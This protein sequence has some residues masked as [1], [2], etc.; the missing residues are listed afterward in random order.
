MGQTFIRQDIQ[1]F[2]SDLYS[3]ALTPGSTLQSGAAIFVYVERNS[4]GGE[5]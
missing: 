4:G 1:I 3:G 5:P 2:K